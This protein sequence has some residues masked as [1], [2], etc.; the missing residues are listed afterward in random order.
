MR[1][2]PKRSKKN[3]NCTKKKNRYKDGV[4]LFFFQAED[5]I[6]DIGVTGVQTCALPISPPPLT[7]P[8]AQS[9]FFEGIVQVLLA[10]CGGPSP[11]VL[12][13]DD[14]HWAD[15][16]SLDLLAYLV[17]RP[18]TGR[19]LCVVLTWRDEQVPPDHHLRGLLTEAQRAR[20]ATVLRLSRLDRAAVEELVGAVVGDTDGLGRRLYD[21]TEGLPLFLGEYLTA[22]M[23]G[24]LAAEDATW[25]LP[26]GVRDLLHGRLETVGET[27]WQLLNTAAVIGRSFDFDT[28]R[29]AS[30]RSEEEA[31]VALEELTDQGLVGEVNGAGER[32]VAYDF[33][34]EK[35]RDLVYE[36][37]S[38]ARRRLL[39]RRVAEALAHR[40]NRRRETGALAGQIAHHYR[41]AG[42]DAEA[43]HHFRVAGEHAR[44]LYANAEAL[45]HF[46]A[47]LALGHP[48]AAELHEAVGDLQTLLGEYGGALASYE[49]SAALRDGDHLSGIER[50]LGNVYQRLGEW[51]LTESHL[52]AALEGTGSTGELARLHA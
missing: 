24:A 51:E 33:G 5:G 37:T 42:R 17:R 44:A 40:A 6:R 16:S 11:G 41:L 7:T 45:A 35:L 13:I 2:Y 34:H 49:T 29:E 21:E 52:D 3:E 28:V 50:K 22:I 18:R 14:V 19:R 47:A 48:D 23:N 20:M 8:G 26:G 32:S 43:A 4:N 46:H 12:F 15:A 10:V 9:R 39:H 30:G 36:E 25:S 38:L 1:M 27:G 31:V